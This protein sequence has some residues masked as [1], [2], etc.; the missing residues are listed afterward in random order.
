MASRKSNQDPMQ[1]TLESIN[2][3]LQ[4]LLILECAKAGMK[5]AEVIKIIGGDANKITRIWK[6]LNKEKGEQ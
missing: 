6:H 4:G 1:E 3:A 5:K 2:G